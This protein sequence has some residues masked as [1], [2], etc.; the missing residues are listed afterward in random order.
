MSVRYENIRRTCGSVRSSLATPARLVTVW[1]EAVATTS[2]LPGEAGASPRSVH[3]VAGNG[4]WKKRRP[5]WSGAERSCNITPP[6]KRADFQSVVRDER[7]GGTFTG[8][9]SK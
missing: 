5:P 7:T 9:K 3:G 6:C 1:S 4:N 8:G 2:L